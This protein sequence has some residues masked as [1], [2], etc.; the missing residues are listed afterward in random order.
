MRRLLPLLL[1]LVVHGTLAAQEPPR[2]GRWQEEP[3]DTPV[4]NAKRAWIGGVTT[5]S[6]GDYQPSGVDVAYGVRTAG[7]PVA[8]VTAGLR[9]G[10]FVQNQAVLIGRT[11][12]FFVEAVG[13]LRRPLVNVL[14][15]GEENN[16]SYFR[17]EFWLEGG[18]MIAANNPMPQGARSAAVAGLVAASFG[19]RHALDQAIQ[20]VVGPAYLMGAQNSWHTEVGLRFQ[21]PRR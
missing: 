19:G 18:F 20:I 16:L 2:R 17:L 14:A 8:A 15:I 7:L 13:T 9:V 4:V 10:S 3:A 5:F 6:R 21:N 1:L 11:Q 12:G